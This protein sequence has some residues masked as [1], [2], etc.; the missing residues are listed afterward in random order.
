MATGA[1]ALGAAPAAPTGAGSKTVLPEIL[2][3]QANVNATLDTMATVL[4]ARRAMAATQMD[5]FSSSAAWASYL[6]AR[7]ARATPATM[8]TGGAARAARRATATRWFCKRVRSTA[9]PT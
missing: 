5:S 2:P 1:T 8:A 9:S 4:C 7:R 3:I 6:T